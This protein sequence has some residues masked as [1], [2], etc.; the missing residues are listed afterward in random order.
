MLKATLIQIPER[1]VM[2]EGG[3]NLDTYCL[4]VPNQWITLYLTVEHV[5][6]WLHFTVG[7]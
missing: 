7:M 6:L 4:P 5:K 1:P 3:A 2:V